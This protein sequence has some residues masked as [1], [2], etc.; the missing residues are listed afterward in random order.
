MV[1][2]LNIDFARNLFLQQSYS[3]SWQDY[4]YLLTHKK[5][6]RW[7]WF[8]LTASNEKQAQTYEEQI[9]YRLKNGWLPSETKYLVIPDPK[10]E[11]VGS[12]GATL[13]A[14]K[15]I[16]EK[17][18]AE[19]AF[20]GK[21]ILIIHSGGD[22][23]RIPQYSACGKLFSR[24][25]RELPDGRCSTLFDEFIIALSGIPSRM[26]D[27]V[28]VMSGDV[29]LLFNPLQIDLQRSGSACISIK[30]PVET[31]E[32]HGVFLEGEKGYVGGFLHKQPKDKLEE[33]GAV[34]DMGFVDIDTGA[35]W[36]SSCVIKNLISV[37]SE[38]GRIAERLVEKYVNSKIRLSFYGDFIY[39]MTADAKL[40]DYL[41]QPTE[42]IYC[43][44]LAECRRAIWNSLCQYPMKLIRLSPAE[45]IHFGTTKELHEL[46][47]TASDK[48][49]HL[50][51]KRTVMSSG[52]SEV[53]CINSIIDKNARVAK[54]V[55]IEDSYISYDADISQGCIVSN[56]RFSG[57]LE[58]NTVLH[59]LPVIYKNNLC[60]TARI[61][62][63]SDNPKKGL[64][65]DGTFM[66]IPLK[67]FIS[68]YNIPKDEIWKDND[69]SL[70]TAKLYTVCKSSN[71]ALQ[72]ALFLQKAAAGCAS[73]DE[74]T[75]WLKSERMSLYESFENA[76]IKE[77]IKWQ[78]NLEDEV[79]TSRFIQAMSNGLRADDAGSILGTG[80]KLV[81]RLRIVLKKTVEAET[82]VKYRVFR[83]LAE[84]VRKNGIA[85]E[86]LNADFLEDQCYRTV[87]EEIRE[88]ILK[89]ISLMSNGNI[90][91]KA[92]DIELPVRV[93][94][95]GG[96]S[97]TPPYCIEKGGTVLNA[98]ISLRGKFPVKASV[99]Q[100][101]KPVIVL[102]SRDL[103]LR[104]EF[105][106]GEELQC[107]DNTSDVFALHKAALIASGVIPQRG[108]KINLSKELKKLGGGL[109][110]CTDV[111]VPKGSG[112]GTSSILAGAL[113][114]SLACVFGKDHDT[115]Y[116][117]DQVLCIEQ[118]MTTGGGWQ[119]Q[120][121]AL[122]PG[123]KLASSCPG[124]PQKVNVE[125]LNVSEKTVKELNQRF[126]L[127][128]TGQRRLARD[129][130]REIMS[131]YIL[132]HE[133]T[134]EVLRAIQHL[135]VLMRF[136]LEKGNVDGFAEL[137]DKHW[138][139]SKRLDKNA[140]NSCIEHI[141]HVCRPMIDGVFIGGAGGGGFLQMILKKNVQRSD[142][143]RVLDAVFQ[144]NG[145]EIWDSSLVFDIPDVS[146]RIVKI[147]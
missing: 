141:I 127:V 76:N 109:Y 85:D 79:R 139:L 55:Y 28:L 86:E 87:N 123:I 63:V 71:E 37:I 57:R 30:A 135:A 114:K 5:S 119:D 48:H 81:E 83:T 107:C 9:R 20:A 39:P 66:G 59:M 129:I 113:A 131:K 65:D 56:V 68:R 19:D 43:E 99:R 112:L 67:D 106:D 84:V 137:L 41:R 25:P 38:K 18:G 24:V 73:E 98:A 47:M 10:G 126:V 104:K 58:A 40:E 27:G 49:R 105:D 2:N 91:L 8:V 35:V 31:G 74:I 69:N 11:R 97:D 100:L 80:S 128:Y 94:W 78:E 108:T 118:L 121:G 122:I 70:W 1:N 33:A 75:A 140:T 26:S 42:G 146:D 134:L 101:N 110:I 93:N 52:T 96:W 23:K 61:Y 132:G 29:L 36:M 32:R 50:G 82:P 12:G 145:I 89:N 116:L 142:L 103:G 143:K 147:S 14:L 77:I 115:Q 124:I 17:S 72:S 130:L 21:K 13:N 88:K 120:V 95:G 22:S 54:N 62:N 117:I 60:Y 46:M 6:V 4:K 53:T 138:E 3:D 16:A 44:E 45:F 64:K 111:D 90:V 15:H 125:L 144:G 133:D 34:N 51:W 102:E 92:V 136:E 7:D